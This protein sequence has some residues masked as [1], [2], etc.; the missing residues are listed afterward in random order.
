MWRT[1]SPMPLA[2]SLV[3][4]ETFASSTRRLTVTI[5]DAFLDGARDRGILAPRAR[6]DQA[7]DA[8]R[9]QRVDQH[10]ILRFG[11][12]SEFAIIAM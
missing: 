10:R 6:Q 7:V 8:A 1:A 5:G 9:P 11:S 4:D 2:S 12:L 3:T